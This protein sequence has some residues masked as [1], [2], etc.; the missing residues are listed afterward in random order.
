MVRSMCVI[1]KWS[2]VIKKVFHWHNK[3]LRKPFMST[4]QSERGNIWNQIYKFCSWDNSIGKRKLEIISVPINIFYFTWAY[5][6]MNFTIWPFPSRLKISTNITDSYF[7]HS[8]RQKK[9]RMILL[10]NYQQ[11][12][13]PSDLHSNN[14]LHNR[15]FYYFTIRKHRY[16]TIYLC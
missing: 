12:W 4:W 7:T 13:Q 5:K 11:I 14:I 8:T 9:L 16:V 3:V 10:A 6:Q 1:L 15:L 2:Y